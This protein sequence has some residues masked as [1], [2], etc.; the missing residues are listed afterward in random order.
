M[1]ILNTHAETIEAQATQSFEMFAV[2]DPGID[3]DTDFRVRRKIKMLA[4][5]S[6]QIVKL[7]RGEISR[8]AAAP[9]K[10]HHRAIARHCS[11]YMFDFAL[12]NIEVGYRDS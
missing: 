9:M 1:K 4:R 5:E 11:S 8:G 3:L 7:L 10:L 6:K 12:Q 2:G